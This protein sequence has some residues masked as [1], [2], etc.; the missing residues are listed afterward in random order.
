MSERLPPSLVVFLD[1]LGIAMV[2]TN[3]NYE[4]KDKEPDF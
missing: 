3:G 4:F 1:T 2:P